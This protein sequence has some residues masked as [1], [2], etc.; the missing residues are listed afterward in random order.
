MLTPAE[1]SELWQ[2]KYSNYI[3]SNELNEQQILFIE[4]IRK[5]ITPEFFSDVTYKNSINE[6]VIRAKAISLFG[7]TEAF[8]LLATLQKSSNQVTNFVPEQGDLY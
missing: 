6:K 2:E 1:K 3:N 8:T 5:I 7:P 4:S